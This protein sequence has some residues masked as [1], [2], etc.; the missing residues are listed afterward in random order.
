MNEPERVVVVLAVPVGAGGTPQVL[1]LLSG[2]PAQADAAVAELR[3]AIRVAGSV[4]GDGWTLTVTVAAAAVPGSATDTTPAPAR[5]LA[6]LLGGPNSLGGPAGRLADRLWAAHAAVTRPVPSSPEATMAGLERLA[7]EH[8]FVLDPA[9]R[10]EVRS[11]AR[12]AAARVW[13]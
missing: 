11:A 5:A 6:L 13:L 4:P 1:A 8:G 7:V 12:K 3:A 10:G 2:T 9:L